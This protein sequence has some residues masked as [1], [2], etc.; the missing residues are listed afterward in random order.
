M[1]RRITKWMCVV[2]IGLTAV[3]AAATANDG[4]M[5][6]ATKKV[7]IKQ[8]QNYLNSVRSLKARFSQSDP[9]SGNLY[10]GSL[11][12]RRGGKIRVQYD[13]PYGLIMVGSGGELRY[14]DQKMDKVNSTSTD[15]TPLGTLLSDVV[16]FEKDMKVLDVRKAFGTIRM[17]VTKEGFGNGG[18]LV[19]VFSDNP[20]ALRQWVVMDQKQN[21]INFSLINPVYNDSVE[22]C[23]FDLNS[24][25]KRL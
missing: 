2:V 16:D 20:I 22:E 14:Y 25:K 8:V 13:L 6:D 9:K 19:L 5:D 12:L 15:S 11:V 7:L 24:V 1:L 23:N 18:Y 21:Q 10:Q 17:L 4:K 3:N